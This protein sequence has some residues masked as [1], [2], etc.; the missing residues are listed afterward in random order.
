M[1]VAVFDVLKPVTDDQ[2]D[3]AGAFASDGFEHY[4]TLIGSGAVICLCN[5]L[6]PID[7]NNWLVPAWLI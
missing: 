4:G 1:V 2:K 3:D 5:D 7:R 6:L